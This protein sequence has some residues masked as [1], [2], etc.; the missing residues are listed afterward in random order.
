[1]LID[2][3]VFRTRDG[4]QLN[5]ITEP[6]L[7][8]HFVLFPFLPYENRVYFGKFLTPPATTQ[9]PIAISHRVHSSTSAPGH[10]YTPA[11]R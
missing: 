5:Q 7:A 11:P 8:C 2:C 3:F 4:F 6:K 10:A 1:M 9:E